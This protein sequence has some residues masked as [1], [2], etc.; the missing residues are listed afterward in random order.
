MYQDIVLE[1]RNSREQIKG[2]TFKKIEIKKYSWGPHV[3]FNI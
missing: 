3:N 1:V 2:V